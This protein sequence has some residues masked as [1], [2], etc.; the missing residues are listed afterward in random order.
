MSNI[1][2]NIHILEI[3]ITKKQGKI[4]RKIVGTRWGRGRW[5]RG[6]GSFVPLC[7]QIPTKE[8][9]PIRV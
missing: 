4:N 3:I 9:Q 5:G 2:V 8:N 6:D 1:Q 7:K